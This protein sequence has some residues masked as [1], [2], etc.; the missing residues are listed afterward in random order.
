MN[1]TDDVLWVEDHEEMCCDVFVCVTAKNTL[2]VW[3]LKII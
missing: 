1:G 3:T 2:S